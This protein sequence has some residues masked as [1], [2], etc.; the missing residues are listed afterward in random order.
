MERTEDIER[1]RKRQINLTRSVFGGIS[2]ITA[3]SF[4]HPV[5]TIKIRLQ[6]QGEL[7]RSNQQAYNNIFRAGYV[8]LKNEGFRGLYK[9]VSASWLREGVYSSLRLGLYEPFKEMLGETDPK[10]TPLW[11]KFVAGS[12]AGFVGSVIGNPTD[13]LK[14]RMQA[15]E[16]SPKSLL[17]HVKTVHSS[18]G[19]VGFYK[20]VEANV[21]RAT[22]L[23]A[24]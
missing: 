22:I 12:L 14:V 5:D 7:G 2:C 11:M 21:L 9:G 13:M 8:I 4:T 19:I 6:I 18:F 24:T 23:N 3:A 15:W 1:R 16:S 20:G 10:N 17:W